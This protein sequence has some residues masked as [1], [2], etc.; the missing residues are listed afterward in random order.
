MSKVKKQHLVPKVY[1][2]NFSIPVKKVWP[3]YVFDKPTQD[4]YTSNVNDVASSNYYYDIPDEYNEANLDP[5]LVEKTFSTMEGEY[6]NIL[7]QLIQNVEACLLMSLNDSPL[8][9][10]DN[11]KLK[12]SFYIALQALRTD[13]YRR[14][15]EDVTSGMLEKLANNYINNDSNKPS[16][17]EGVKIK[18]DV[19]PNHTQMQHI[20]VLG[21]IKFQESLSSIFLSKIWII[22][23]ND[24][25]QP[26]YTSDHPLTLHAHKK[27]PFL[28][29]GYDSPYTELA[30]PINSKIVLKMI[31]RKSFGK[32]MMRYENRLIKLNEENIKYYNSLQVRGASR[33][34]YC[35]K[36][37][38]SLAVSFTNDYPETRNPS[39]KRLSTE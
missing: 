37:N 4:V 25:S 17:L 16:A 10:S 3:I 30:F 23:Y 24:T 27:D 14:M 33:Q 38:F 26:L 9:L 22:G 5:Q 8:L 21:D 1:L 34:I 2:R 11:L 6:G 12:L 15:I 13:E 20:A 36:D 28:G 39:R 31:D 35:E 18:A 19:F 7:K 32:T 29:V